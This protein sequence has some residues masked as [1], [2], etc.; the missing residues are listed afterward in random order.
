MASALPVPLRRAA[1]PAAA[2]ALVLPLAL[3]PEAPAAVAE[4]EQSVL[5]SAADDDGYA[6]FR[7]PA[8][9]RTTDDTLLAFAEGRREHCGDAG[10]IDIV[11]RRSDDEGRTWGPVELVD[12]GGGDTHGNPAPMVDAATGRVL[13]AS[14]RNPDAGTGNCPAPCERVPFLSVS[15]DDGVTWSEPRDL[16]AELRP[17]GWNSWYATGPLHGVQL[18]SEPHEGRLVFSVNAESWADGRITENHAA[19]ALSDDGGATWRLGAVD[20]WPVAAD[21]THR[22]RPSEM[23]VAELGDGSVYVNTREQDGTDLG[24][25]DHAV[26]RD[27]GESFAAPFEAIPDLYAPQVQGSLLRLRTAADDGHDRL[28]LAVPA[29]PDRR[30]TMMIRSSWDEGRTWDSADRGAVLT[31]DWAG[32][33]DMAETADGAVAL[34]YEAGAVDARDEI[35]FARVSEEWLGPRRAPDPVTPDDAPGA[36][37]A[38]VL[39]GAAPVAGRFGN[40]LAFDGVNSAVRLPFRTSLP[41][42]EADFTV[43]LWFRYEAGSGEHPFLWMGG[44]GGAPQVWV[45]GEPERGRVRALLTAVEGGNEPAN[46]EVAT[47]GAFNDGG[48]HHLALTRSG[49]SL[50]LAVDGGAA[51]TAPDV[52]GT[53][54]RS[55]TFGVHLGQRPDN[56]QRLVGA[57]DEVRVW[58]RALT[59]DELTDVRESNAAP[60]EADDAAVLRLPLDTVDEP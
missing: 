54:S 39:G 13:L 52:P 24:H 27:G 34:L 22:Q 38:P 21:G 7:I 37:P 10:D 17:D 50:S 6:C 3:A 48:W 59:P 12:E 57:L 11:L 35:R 23:A 55:S 40:G 36:P 60:P 26:S 43:S 41:L 42:G 51:V 5:F 19:L 4:P 33:S 14:T 31:T 47:E 28:L 44:V 25:R 58:R 56:A 18:A 53:V 8:L 1:G 32:Y 29:D 9:V 20:S 2:A 49:G 45:R 30:R 46:A 15:D 16:G